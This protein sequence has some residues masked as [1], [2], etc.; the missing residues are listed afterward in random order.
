MCF[1]PSGHSPSTGATQ[2][3]P[4]YTSGSCRRASTDASPDAC[5]P[6]E[7]LAPARL[8]RTAPT[9]AVGAIRIGV[10][11]A[12]GEREDAEEGHSAFHGLTFETG[13]EFIMP[14]MAV[15]GFLAERCAPTRFAAGTYPS[16]HPTAAVVSSS[17][18]VHCRAGNGTHPI[19]GTQNGTLS[20]SRQNVASPNAAPVSYRQ[21]MISVRQHPSSASQVAPS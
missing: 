7:P 15:T 19:S 5:S 2:P 13:S 18:A 8:A 6:P 9:R 3:G 10:R 14:G 20:A 12:R 21:L 17:A 16:G 11:R 1:V 4:E